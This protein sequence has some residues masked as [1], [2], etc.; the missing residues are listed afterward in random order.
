[1]LDLGISFSDVLDK[2]HNQAKTH[3]VTP[4]H[5]ITKK[6][7]HNIARDFRISKAR[8]NHC[9]DADSAVSTDRSTYISRA[10]AAYNFIVNG[11]ADNCT[12]VA[13]VRNM[14]DQ[15]EALKAFMLAYQNRPQQL[16]VFPTATGQPPNTRLEP[17]KRFYSTKK[18]PLK[19][20]TDLSLSKPTLVEKQRLL[21]SLSG[22]RPLISQS[23]LNTDHDYESSAADLL[24]F[25]H[26][27]SC[28]Q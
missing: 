8:V 28:G 19:R 18:K 13:M 3:R 24:N 22:Q 9:N 15:L 1:M 14:C 11:M 26:S 6:T 23:R 5:L 25:E 2:V 21:A 12:D 10:T 4:K 17:Q 16:P 27:Y 7:L 20:P